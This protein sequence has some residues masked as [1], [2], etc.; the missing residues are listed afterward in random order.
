MTPT[1][2]VGGRAVCARH[3]T[4]EAQAVCQRCG[5]HLCTACAAFGCE[6]PGCPH[7]GPVVG[8]DL[9]SVPVPWE[10]RGD[11]GWVAALAH[12]WR[13]SLLD[14]WRFFQDLPD[15]GRGPLAYGVV[16]GTLGL[17]LGSLGLVLARPELGRPLVVLALVALPAVLHLRLLAIAGVS[18]LVLLMLT[19]QREWSRVIQV[20]G[21]AASIDA[22]MAIPGFGIALASPA[23]G[24]LRGVGLHRSTGAG[25]VPALVAGLAPSFSAGLAVMGVVAAWLWVTS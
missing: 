10:A 25:L 23:A 20:T 12:T 11:L 8:G 1:A 14:P 17:G 3:D 21:Y 16:V 5:D 6:E 24:I 4:A 18:W 13:R 9:W 2:T 19:G 15:Q 22:L 7:R